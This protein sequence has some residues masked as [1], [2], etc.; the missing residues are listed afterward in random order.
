MDYIEP[1]KIKQLKINV[2]HLITNSDDESIR[3]NVLQEIN[4]LIEVS[5]QN[6]RYLHPAKNA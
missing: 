4:L 3:N 1:G 2:K 6:R 5:E